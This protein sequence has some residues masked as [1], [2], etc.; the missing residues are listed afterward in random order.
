[1]KELDQQLKKGI[2]EIII[3]K[4]IAEKDSYGYQIVKDLSGFNSLAIKEGSLYP[5]LYRLEDNL[6]IESS[7]V[8]KIKGKPKKYYSITPEGRAV[9]TKNLVKWNEFVADVNNILMR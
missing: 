3:L 7:W 5:I 4:L 1:M 9:L 2:I 8:N 6:F